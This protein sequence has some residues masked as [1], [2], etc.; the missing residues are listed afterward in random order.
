[1]QMRGLYEST[2]NE[3]VDTEVDNTMK[4]HHCNCDCDPCTCEECK[5]GEK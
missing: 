1:M 2:K 3:A 4:K 5:C